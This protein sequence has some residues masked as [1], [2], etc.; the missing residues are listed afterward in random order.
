MFWYK[1]IH[2]V[3]HRLF[4][5]HNL[6]CK[7]IMEIK[8]KTLCKLALQVTIKT[9]INGNKI[10]KNTL[11]YI[12]MYSIFKRHSPYKAFIFFINILIY[13]FYQ[14]RRYYSKKFVD[15]CK[16]AIQL[17]VAELSTFGDTVGNFLKFHYAGKIWKNKIIPFYRTA[18]WRTPV[19]TNV[20]FIINVRRDC[21]IILGKSQ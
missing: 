7:V 13:L 14:V 4:T 21:I 18:V 17:Q 5:I 9:K 10:K 6:I 8:V 19:L 20:C 16:V 3:I 1:V 11:L 12:V 15:W 2:R